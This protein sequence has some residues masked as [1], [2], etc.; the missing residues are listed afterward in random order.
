MPDRIICGVDPGNAYIGLVRIRPDGLDLGVIRGA[1]QPRP[2]KRNPK[3]ERLNPYVEAHAVATEVVGWCW[4]GSVSGV[5]VGVEA[6]AMSRNGRQD[7]L[8]AARQ[9]LFDAIA[10]HFGPVGAVAFFA[11]VTPGQAKKALTGY[12]G[13]DKRRMVEAAAAAIRTRW[14]D[15]ESA[16]WDLSDKEREAVADALGIALHLEGLP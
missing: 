1:V 10:K 4:A 6:G 8:A 14:P 5:L 15:G 13:A 12:V 9:A 7:A 3:P 16:W 11:P 2:S